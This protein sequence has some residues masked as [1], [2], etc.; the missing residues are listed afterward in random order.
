MSKLSAMRLQ[1]INNIVI[2]AVFAVLVGYLLSAVAVD[3]KWF[4]SIAILS[5]LL[6]AD[7]LLFSYLRTRNIFSFRIIFLTLTLL[8]HMGYSWIFLFNPTYSFDGMDFEL[9][10]DA[11]TV[12][13]SYLFSLAASLGIYIGMQ[14]GDVKWSSRTW[15]FSN[16]IRS[17]AD[18]PIVSKKFTE[19]SYRNLGVAVLLIS[20]PIR[21]YIDIGK[22]RLSN[23]GD[24]LSTF[25]L[26]I[27]GYAS[28]LA[29]MSIIGIV[30]LLIYYQKKRY[31]PSLVMGVSIFYYVMSMASGSRGTA[32]ISI[33]ILLFAYTL[34]V[35]KFRMVTVI[36]IGVLS[37]VLISYLTNLGL[38]R[39]SSSPQ[40]DEKYG[41]QSRF[42]QE[43][44]GTQMT[45]I[46][47]MN[48]IDGQFSPHYSFGE[49]YLAA[50]LTIFP[51]LTLEYEKYIDNN[52]FQKQ[53]NYPTIGGSY[54]AEFYYNF[55]YFALSI[56]II[57][58]FFLSKFERFI[59]RLR[60]REQFILLAFSIFI[61]RQSLWWIRDTALVFPRHMVAGLIMMVILCLIM[62]KFGLIRQVG[63]RSEVKNG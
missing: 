49:T 54:I 2:V 63:G 29:D 20:V 56:A 36:G 3:F 51:N 13:K 37:I 24:Y 34:C 22:I 15:G 10:F 23:A 38:D 40:L 21:L 1:S 33:V 12:F 53:L 6:L 42:L 47:T 35:R 32:V 26:Q 31:A 58:G 19:K 39:I 16:K 59:T 60:A 43:F 61:A 27:N 18:K 4:S 41:M 11:T 62:Q 45:T 55:G 9:M 57:V 52:N 28:M 25:D 48:M 14:I 5:V 7:L 50:S 30:L 8:F 44:G 17:L 46:L